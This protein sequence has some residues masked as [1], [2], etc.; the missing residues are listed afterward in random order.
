[1]R[2]IHK[3]YYMWWRAG[4]N[5]LNEL[6]F[7]MPMYI[8]IYAWYAHDCRANSFNIET[9]SCL[10][11]FFFFNGQ[12]MGRKQHKREEKK[13]CGILRIRKITIASRAHHESARNSFVLK[14]Q[15][16]FF[17]LSAPLLAHSRIL[18]IFAFLSYSWLKMLEV[19]WDLS[20]NNKHTVKR[21]FSFWRWVLSK[22]EYIIRWFIFHDFRNIVYM[23][24]F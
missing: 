22:F 11:Y 15:F 3:N 18:S 5:N 16:N 14:F 13:Y 17:L 20:R 2:H 12:L 8:T 7:S 24:L 4:E 19:V 9:I 1:M 10:A 23:K 21:F 6:N